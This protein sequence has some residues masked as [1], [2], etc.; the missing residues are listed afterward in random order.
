M[1]SFWLTDLQQMVTDS[2]W[3]ATGFSLLPQKRSLKFPS[4]S[5]APRKSMKSEGQLAATPVPPV[6]L[7][8]SSPRRLKLKGRPA[9][10]V[11]Q[12]AKQIVVET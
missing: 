7:F 4:V 3:S 10:F 9:F 5:K 11:G 8:K 12:A 6:L 1:K 2:V